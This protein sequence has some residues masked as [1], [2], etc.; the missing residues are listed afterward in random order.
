M[1]ELEGAAVSSGELALTTVA[2][3][4][5]DD[6]AGVRA[7]SWSAVQRHGFLLAVLAAA[8]FAG[9]LPLVLAGCCAPPGATGFGM[10]WFLNDYAQ[11]E[12]AIRQGAQQPGWLIYDV[13]TPEPHQP[14]LMFTLYVWL[15]KLSALAH[16]SSERARTRCRGA[17]PRGARDQRCG[18]SARRSPTAAARPRVATLLA[19]FGGG[20]ALF[21]AACTR[22]MTATGRSKTTRSDCCSPRRTFHWRMACTLELA[23]MLAAAEPRPTPWLILATAALGAAIALLHPFHEP[24]LLATMFLVGPGVLAHRAGTGQPGRH[25]RGQP[26]R[27]ACLVADGPDVQLRPVLVGYLPRAKH[28]AH[29]RRRTS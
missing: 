22:R 4:R 26:R 27:A 23:R 1:A 9:L 11:Y 25:A 20:F 10:A 6:R 19:L 15:G 3:T 2:A 28:P 12:S 29:A 24:M 14:A 7:V 5:G 18:A 17:G 13:F 8:T 16:V 21:A